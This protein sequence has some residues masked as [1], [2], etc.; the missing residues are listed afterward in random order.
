MVTE[1]RPYQL[2]AVA[3]IQAG[4]SGGRRR[5]LAVLP[6]GAGKTIV[7]LQAAASLARPTVIL[8][9]NAAI[10]GQW[11]AEA[12]RL[13]GGTWGGR[14]PTTARDRQLAADITSLTYQAVA[15]FDSDAEVDESGA[16]IDGHEARLSEGAREFFAR[17]AGLGEAVLILDECHHLVQVWGELLDEMLA[18]LPQV[19]VLGLTA[20]PAGALSASQAALTTRLLGV[21]VFTVSAP[22]LVR[23]G[24]LAPYAEFG[25][26]CE[27]TS[28]ER[29]WLLADSERFAELQADLMSNGFASTDFLPWL[30]VFTSRLSRAE[31][32]TIELEQPD[33]ATAI[34]RFCHDDLA[35]APQGA[36]SREERRQSARPQDWALVIGA[37][38]QE[39]LRESSDPRDLLALER[40]RLALPSVGFRLTRLGVQ[41]GRSPVDRVLARSEAKTRAVV[42]IIAAEAMSL[43]DRLRGLVITD[44]ERA[45]AT[46]PGRLV[47]V[48]PVEAGSARLVVAN[49]AADSR[50]SGRGIALVSGATV[51]GNEVAARAVMSARPDLTASRDGDLTYLTGPW[52]TRQWVPL[53]TRM[54]EQGEISVLVGTRALL[55]EGWDARSVSTVVDLSTAT[56]PTSV[57]QTRGRALRV[58]PLWPDKVAHT[59]SVTCVSESHGRG[60][61]DFERLVRKHASYLALNQE[62]QVVTGLSHLDAALTPFAPPSAVDFDAVN[63]RMLARSEDRRGTRERWRIGEAFHDRIVPAVQILSATDEEGTN[64]LAPSPSP[65]LSPPP[66]PA[67]PPP[68]SLTPQVGSGPSRV[69]AT[70]SG[71]SRNEARLSWPTRVAVGGVAAVAVAV[72]ATSWV[73]AAVLAGVAVL[74][75]GLARTRASSAAVASYREAAD[76]PGFATYAEVVA[77]ALGCPGQSRIRVSEGVT[78]ADLPGV[79]A[80]EFAAALDELLGPPASPRYVI[81]RPLLPELPR[82]RRARVRMARAAA[83]GRLVVPVVCHA[84]PTIFGV[85]AE[86][87]TPFTAAWRATV[88]VTE[89]RFARSA[90]GAELLATADSVSPAGLATGIRTVWE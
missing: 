27:P 6:P 38:V 17:L 39:V 63:A 9:P 25:W 58:D 64:T 43:T 21:E 74:A 4:W 33:L 32:R 83:G 72:S 41:R 67:L 14:S 8:S 23:Q 86:A 55:G 15:H 48:I 73:A 57:V 47:G 19:T 26:F 44:H 50:L 31:W 84:V 10:A 11:V 70:P 78:T 46:L 52:T 85:R 1:L 76:E 80:A 24:Y 49:L 35:R 2:Q 68:P 60:W 30:D 65:S 16:A 79:R 77:S 66:S 69:L 75:F 5:A 81:A 59:W 7:G 87:L 20:T 29:D 82:A 28:Q 53:L 12:N 56:T 90:G 40:L 88:A 37:F 54:F 13:A 61:V 42:E 36:A 45:T 22:A 51:A 3:A 18:D 71:V 89:P 62:G 34:M